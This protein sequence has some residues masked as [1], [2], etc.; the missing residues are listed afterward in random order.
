MLTISVMAAGKLYV[1]TKTLMDGKL[2][3]LRQTLRK[4]PKYLMDLQDRGILCSV[5]PPEKDE[6]SVERSWQTTFKRM[7]VVGD[8]LSYVILPSF[9]SLFLNSSVTP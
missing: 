2:T 1:A 7:Q 4:P 6:K 8:S 5:S 9:V 3:T